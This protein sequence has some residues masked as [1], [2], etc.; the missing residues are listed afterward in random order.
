M[1][2]HKREMGAADVFAGL[3]DHL[4]WGSGPLTAVLRS[5]R[6]HKP[7]N[8]RK[9]AAYE[10]GESEIETAVSLPKLL[11][12]KQ[13]NPDDTVKLYP[14]IALGMLRVEQA[15]AGR[16]WL[17]L[18]YLDEVGQ[19]WLRVAII[20]KNLTANHSPIR[21]CGWRQL[22]NLLRQGDGIFWTRDKTRIWLKSAANVAAALGVERL[23]GKPVTVPVRVLT[24]SI[25]Q[26]RAHL[27][28]G[29]H[30]GRCQEDRRQPIA[31]ET[32]TELTG[33]GRRTQ[34]VYE[35]LTGLSVQ[36][37]YAIAE[38]YSPETAEKHAWHQGQATFVFQDSHGTQGRPG[39]SYIAW[40]LPNSYGSC[41]PHAPEGRQRR[42]NRKLTDLVIKG[43]PGN[44]RKRLDTRYYP[45]G[46]QAVKMASRHQEWNIYWWRQRTRNGRSDL[47][48]QVG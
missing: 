9:R 6:R 34:I 7:H 8:N 16:I 24:G 18:R 39:R 46:K 2:F 15:A 14:D 45:D 19:G 32:L 31:R 42:I 20:R 12:V 33:V 26:V 48:Q 11:S 23:T 37:N 13:P 47:W 30:S 22:R 25:G 35:A 40:Q 10:R 21:V 44:S 41:H 27:Y 43:V 17:L 36:H 29:F 1:N 5:T 38:Q 4:G 3:P 28:A